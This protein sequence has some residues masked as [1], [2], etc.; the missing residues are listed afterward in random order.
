MRQYIIKYF[1][2]KS[3][4]ILVPFEEQYVEDDF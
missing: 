4:V 3:E 1:K 2:Q